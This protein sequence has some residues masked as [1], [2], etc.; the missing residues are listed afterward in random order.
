[1]AS[2]GHPGI[3]GC[4]CLSVSGILVGYFGLACVGHAV[5]DA[6]HLSLRHCIISDAM[7]SCVT[8]WCHACMG[9]MTFG[10]KSSQRAWFEA[11]SAQKALMFHKVLCSPG[12]S[13]APTYGWCLTCIGCDTSS[14][15]LG[16]SLLPSSILV[17]LV[18]VNSDIPHQGTRVSQRDPGVLPHSLTVPLPQDCHA[19]QLVPM[20][21]MVGVAPQRTMWLL[22]HGFRIRCMTYICMH[23]D[24]LIPW[25]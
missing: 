7:M 12:S 9:H 20:S 23:S 18:L 22:L 15:S 3:L 25:I 2:G 16:W 5:S 19:F 17:V 10:Y 14:V 1:M 11:L 21:I 4:P 8:S 13:L 6:H 24:I